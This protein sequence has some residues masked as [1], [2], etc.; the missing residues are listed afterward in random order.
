MVCVYCSGDTQVINSRFQKRVNHVWRRR[1]CL[2]CGAI[3]TTHE[4]VSY[5]GSLLVQPTNGQPVP[6]YRDK[7]FV[8]V[9]KSCAHRPSALTDATALTDTI[10]SKLLLKVQQTAISTTDI[11]KTTYQT[12]QHFDRA[13][14]VHYQAFHP[15]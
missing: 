13:A 6:F 7:L 4:G 11:T 9:F 12:L 15:F 2:A 1:K 10:L 14:A 5:A 8:S 3:F